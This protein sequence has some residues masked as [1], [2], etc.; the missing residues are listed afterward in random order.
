VD[1]NKPSMFDKN[2]SVVQK[3]SDDPTAYSNGNNSK[4]Q[5]QALSQ[6]GTHNAQESNNIKENT[7]RVQVHLSES[8]KHTKNDQVQYGT[9][10]N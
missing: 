1:G 8:D 10:N 9:V 2:Q 7:Q 3:S 6:N 4:A 5:S